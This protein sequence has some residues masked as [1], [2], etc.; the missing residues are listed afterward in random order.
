MGSLCHVKLLL[1]SISCQDKVACVQKCALN[2]PSLNFQSALILIISLTIFV[3][4]FFGG[5]KNIQWQRPVE[6]EDLSPMCS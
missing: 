5:A 2:I 3:Q 1:G 4:L 6:R